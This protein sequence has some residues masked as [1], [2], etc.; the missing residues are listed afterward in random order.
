MIYVRQPSSLVRPAP[1]VEPNRLIN[2]STSA[3]PGEYGS[4]RFPRV[5]QGENPFRPRSLQEIEG[6]LPAVPNSMRWP[7]TRQTQRVNSSNR[8]ASKEARLVLFSQ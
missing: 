7:E 5:S 2:G 4:V 3:D 8:R 1:M 6:G